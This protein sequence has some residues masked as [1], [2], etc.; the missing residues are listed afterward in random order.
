[1]DK[2]HAQ[3]SIPPSLTYLSAATDFIAVAGKEVQAGKNDG[4]KK[5][6]E[7]CGPGSCLQ[8]KSRTA[9][10]LCSALLSL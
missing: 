7:D 4:K 6:T 8:G 3:I 9:F 2:N 10:N 5:R 1:M